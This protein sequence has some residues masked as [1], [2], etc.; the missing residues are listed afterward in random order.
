[1]AAIVA[2]ASAGVLILGMSGLYVGLISGYT[3]TIDRSRA[4][5]MVLPPDAKSLLNSGG[6]PARILP[7][8]YMHPDVAEVRDLDGDW[9]RFYGP[10]KKDPSQ[11][12]VSIV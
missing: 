6:L 3:A 11:V 1:M 2:L 8:I 12:N 9:G 10:H 5:I 7:M 4:D